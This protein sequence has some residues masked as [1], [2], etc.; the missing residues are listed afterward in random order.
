MPKFTRAE[1]RLPVKW[2]EDGMQFLPEIRPRSQA[3]TND[4]G[5]PRTVGD[6][7]RYV[8]DFLNVWNRSPPSWIGHQHLKLVT[9]T[10]GLDVTE[11]NE[12]E[13]NESDSKFDDIFNDTS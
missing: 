3:S 9:N 1:V 13:E 7:F 5:R 6:F 10:F 4:D 12:I 8:G 11:L 2:T